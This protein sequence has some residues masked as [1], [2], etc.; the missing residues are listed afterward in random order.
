MLRVNDTNVAL[1]KIAK[2]L[3]DIFTHFITVHAMQVI[4][5]Y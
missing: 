4:F 1:D 5:A 3:H 2:R